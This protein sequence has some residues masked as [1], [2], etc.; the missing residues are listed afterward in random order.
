MHH[1]HNGATEPARPPL[2]ASRPGRRA[3][4]MALAVVLIAGVCTLLGFG[5]RS[6]W[7]LEQL[8]HFRVQYFWCLAIATAWLGARRRSWP[9]IAGAALAVANLALIAP[10]YFGPA[11]PG[12]DRPLT[13]FM[14]L[15]VYFHSRQYQRALDLVRAENPDLVLFLEVTP[16][17]ARA[18][19]V[20]TQEYPFARVL[21]HVDSGGVAIYSRLPI[22]WLAVAGRADNRLPLA[23]TLPCG[24]LTLLCAHPPSPQTAEDFEL[25]NEQLQ[26]IGE[27]AAAQEGP[28]MILGDL[29]ITSWSPYFGDLL[30]ISGL[31]DSRRGFGVQG[32]WPAAPLP[33]RIPIDH[34]LVSREIAVAERRVGPAVGSDHRAI[35]IDFTIGGP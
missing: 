9:A 4:Q 33:L 20:L 3:D 23:V 2:T 14:S 22:E 17:W 10:L 26:A 5:G 35:V 8:S 16:D 32:T 21:P 27:W 19:R 30:E 31:A 11:A 18:L 24:R 7:R 15:N 12:A 34:C 25:R 28:L 29:N 1:Q 13:R 6:I